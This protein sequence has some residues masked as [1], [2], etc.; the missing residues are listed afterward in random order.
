MQYAK[1]YRALIKIIIFSALYNKK[2]NMDMYGV[3]F[4]SIAL[5]TWNNTQTMS[6]LR[7]LLESF[8]EYAN[9]IEPCLLLICRLWAYNGRRI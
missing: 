3:C 4:C 1:R 5:Y 8:A 7:D 6:S 9:K 2:L